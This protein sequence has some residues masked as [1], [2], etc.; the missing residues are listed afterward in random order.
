MSD[1]STSGSSTNSHP[2]TPHSIDGN[3]GSS[4]GGG[5]ASQ[6]QRF[7]PNGNNSSSSGGGEA[8]HAQFSSSQYGSSAAANAEDQQQQ[9]SQQHSI[10]HAYRQPGISS[11]SQ[12]PPPVDLNNH[13]NGNLAHHSPYPSPIM[14]AQNHIF[15][16]NHSALSH[17]NHHPHHHPPGGEPQHR[18][19]PTNTEQGTAAA[20]R[21]SAEILDLDSH[22]VHVYQP[23]IHPDRHFFHSPYGL[24]PMFGNGWS[25]GIPPEHQ[26]SHGHHP[27]PHPGFGDHHGIPPYS[28]HG[29]HPPGQPPP[30]HPPPPVYDVDRNN[31]QFPPEQPPMDYPS[32]TSQA[33]P[34]PPTTQPHGGLPPFGQPNSGQGFPPMAVQPADN[35]QERISMSS[36][37]ASTPAQK[38]PNEATTPGGSA[39]AVA[40]KT[41]GWKGGECKRPK[42][43]N[44]IA[45]NKWFTS[46]GHLKRHYGTT[47]HKV[48]QLFHLFILL[49]SSESELSEQTQRPASRNVPSPF[50]PESRK[51]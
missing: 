18:A 49:F 51:M 26:F 6:Q 10:D 24:P 23:P 5:S 33:Q 13:I 1:M 39:S 15:S 12:P 38:S 45:C 43:Y 14:I 29:Q 31:P 34:P 7:F 44:C 19:P 46:S 25:H 22:K 20:I 9:P 41:K 17:G 37:L 27:P 32:P 48:K 4:G 30:H 47:L 8:H 50:A 2:P 42:T 40:A 36:P 16:P 11:F 21:E 3:G 28:I 35:R